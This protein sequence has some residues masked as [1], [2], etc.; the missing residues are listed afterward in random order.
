[1]V[2]GYLP[3]LQEEY[4]PFVHS[5][6]ADGDNQCQFFSVVAGV[7]D[8]QGDLVSHACVKLVNI[9]TR[10]RVEIFVPEFLPLDAFFAAGSSSFSTGLAWISPTLLVRYL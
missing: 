1:M 6:R 7:F 2:T 10:N 5:H 3:F 9:F 4:S 8:L